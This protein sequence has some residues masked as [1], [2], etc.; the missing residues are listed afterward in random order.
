[1]TFGIGTNPSLAQVDVQ[2][3]YSLAQPQLPSEVVREGVT[4]R[5]QSTNFVML[6]ALHSPDHSRDALFL[7]NYASISLVDPL[8]RLPGVGNVIIFGQQTYGMRIWLNPDRLAQLG[9]TAA[10]VS[11]AIN[12]QNQQLAA[13]QMGGPPAPR[14]QQFEYTVT[15][16]SRLASVA[17][18]ENVILKANTNGT[19]VCLKDVARVELGSQTYS[20]FSRYN[21]SPSVIIAVYPLPGANALQVSQAVQAELAR[22]HQ[23]LPPGVST[24]IALDTTNFVTESINEVVFTLALAFVLVFV[25][26]FIFLENWRS[27]IIPMIVVPVSLVG[28]CAAFHALGFSLNT[29]TLFGRVLA[30]GLVVDDAIVV[31]EAVRHI[32]EDKMAPRDA[33]R[34][35]MS[36]VAGPVI[37]IALVLSSVF[38]PVAFMGGISGQLYRQFALT[39]VASVV[40]SAFEALTLSP[41]LCALILRPPCPGHGI[42]G[43]FTKWFNRGFGSVQRSYERTVS[44][45]T[46]HRLAML[47][48]LCAVGAAAY[49][50]FR[51]LPSSLSHSKTRAIS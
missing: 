45:L 15:T 44:V 40:L 48:A 4:I 34:Q 47:I 42:F 21:S 49:F 20:S 14:G 12:D 30:I 22:L 31:V 26:V 35:A 16:N 10:D 33:V 13:G 38:V 50:L 46:H 39:L 3:R 1:M 23:A 29:L 28:A 41:A 25:V 18:F 43:W 6:I 37:A 32:D 2:N 17:Q 51:I 9:L 5:K 19:L 24:A 27:T 8:S 11:T 36:E 7:S